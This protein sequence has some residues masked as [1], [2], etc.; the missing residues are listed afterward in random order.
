MS[1]CQ[2]CLGTLY[3]RQTSTG[4]PVRFRHHECT[5]TFLAAVRAG[6]PICT[7]LL[8]NISI[9]Q[10]ADVDNFDDVWCRAVDARGAPCTTASFYSYETTMKVKPTQ[11]WNGCR[12]SLNFEHSDLK[13]SLNRLD[14]HDVA[15]DPRALFDLFTSS[16]MGTH[17]GPGNSIAVLT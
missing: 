16:G 17:T 7:T 4:D 6:C 10:A 3:G 1:L 5:S 12:I 9:D 2:A 15:E 11:D 8:D 13:L 14:A